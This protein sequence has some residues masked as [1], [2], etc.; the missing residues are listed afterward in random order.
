M[1]SLKYSLALASL[2]GLLAIASCTL[3]TDVDRSKIPS[4]DASTGDE[5]GQ[6]NGGG[7]NAGGGGASG[8]GTGE[9]AGEAGQGPATDVTNTAGDAG[10]AGSSIP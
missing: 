2:G 1:R 9:A 7:N 3:I 8:G 10:S 4:P 5:A 6:S